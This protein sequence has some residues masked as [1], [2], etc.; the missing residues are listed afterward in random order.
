MF[1][2]LLIAVFDVSFSYKAALANNQNKVSKQVVTEAV[3]EITNP[4]K[5]S[6]YSSYWP[7]QMYGYGRTRPV[8][9]LKSKKSKLD[10]IRSAVRNT[11][12]V[13]SP[14]KYSNGLSS[15]SFDF[16]LSRSMTYSIDA[17]DSKLIT[18][19]SIRTDTIY[20]PWQHSAENI[21]NKFKGLHNNATA[22][23]ADNDNDVE[24]SD[25]CSSIESEV[26]E[27]SSGSQ[28]YRNVQSKSIGTSII[29]E[30]LDKY[31]EEETDMDDGD[32]W[33]GTMSGKSITIGTTN[34]GNETD[35]YDSYSDIEEEDMIRTNKNLNNNSHSSLQKRYFSNRSNHNSYKKS[36]RDE[37][38]YSDV[39]IEDMTID[40][41]FRS[42]Q[43]KQKICDP[44]YRSLPAL[45]SVS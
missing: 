34:R 21:N 29:S 32:T 39:S 35:A 41:S 43:P 16:Q 1:L 25:E 17:R 15:D 28:S 42:L 36:N 20:S 38:T 14:A 37:R 31:G 7:G 26:E 22:A 2:C 30:R 11:L 19:A 8:K 3:L 24:N 9:E 6:T 4:I 12:P 5:K 13:L 10:A 18:N 45:K 33:G 40:S 23:S 44:R 27:H